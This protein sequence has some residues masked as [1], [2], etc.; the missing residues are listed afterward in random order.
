MF[1][2][3]VPEVAAQARHVIVEC[4]AE[5]RGDL[6]ALLPG[7]HRGLAPAH[8]RQRLGAAPRAAARRCRSPPARSRCRFRRSAGRLPAAARFL[9]ADPA[10]VAA[11]RARLDALGPGR[12]IGLSWR[13]GVGFTGK[14]RRSL[15]LEQLLPVLRLPGMQFVNL[16]YTDVREEMRA[17]EYAPLASSVHHWQEAI[18]DYDQTA[19][20]VARARQRAH[21]VHGHRAPDAARSGDRRW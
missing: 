3:C 4:D 10:S 15:S 13:G 7:M 8:A 18:D 6:P 2:S 5:A 16:Q 20:L 11:W 14:K 19:A 12:K 9:Q 1:G 21:G 17:L